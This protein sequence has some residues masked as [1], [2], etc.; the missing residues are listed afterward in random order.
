MSAKEDLQLIMVPGLIRGIVNGHDVM[1]LAKAYGLPEFFITYSAQET[2]RSYRPACW[3][4][5]RLGFY[6]DPDAHWTDYKT[7]TFKV[8][9]LVDLDRKSAREQQK[10]KAMAWVQER[11]GVSLWGSIP[12][13][14]GS[15]FPVEVVALVKRLIR[16]E[17][18][19][20]K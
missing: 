13:L 15:L 20:N 8:T 11:Y 2:G 10:Q 14:P 5:Y 16:E 12:G 3:R 18:R 4:V 7:K 9:R 6:T 1:S 19:K 17:K